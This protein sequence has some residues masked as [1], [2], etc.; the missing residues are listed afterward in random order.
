MERWIIAPLVFGLD[1]A[2]SFL[3]NAP[4]HFAIL[5]IPIVFAVISRNLL[6][7]LAV[8]CLSI[9]TAGALLRPASV[10][11]LI[12]IGS[13][14]GSLFVAMLALL[15]RRKEN[16]VETRLADLRA[17]VDELRLAEERRALVELRSAE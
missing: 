11:V 16:R 13:Y 7:L 8:T 12:A 6:T 1:R 3:E 14:L 17:D 15:Y 2:Q 10:G 9:I 4:D 5:I